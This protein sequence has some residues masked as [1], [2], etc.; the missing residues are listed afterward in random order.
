MKKPLPAPGR[1]GPVGSCTPKGALVGQS[2]LVR[3]TVGPMTEMIQTYR[4]A[5]QLLGIAPA[6]V[7]NWVRGGRLPAPPWSAEEIED[8]DRTIE[9]RGQERGISSQHGTAD[10]WAAGCTCGECRAAH[11]EDTGRRRR[12][13]RAAWWSEREGILVEGLASGPPYQDALEAA[14][15]SWQAITR[16]RK[17][18]SGFAERVDAAL[19]EGRPDVNHGRAAGWRGGC[20]CPE[21]REYHEGTRV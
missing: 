4:R 18:D 10:R 13:Q 21:F 5:G 20:R 19:M 8:A 17:A 12:R 1:Q 2:P 9:N 3:G 6:T 15:V 14:G 11:S 7:R 16:W